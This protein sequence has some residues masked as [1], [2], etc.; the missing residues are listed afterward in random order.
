M[1]SMP[2]G[3]SGRVG[4]SLGVPVA[5]SFPPPLPT[6]MRRGI[7]IAASVP[8]PLS[9]QLARAPRSSG[10]PFRCRVPRALCVIREA[11][12][13]RAATCQDNW[14]PEADGGGQGL[15]RTGAWDQ[16]AVASRR[17]LFALGRRLLRR[18]AGRVRGVRV[19]RAGR[20]GPRPLHPVRSPG[21]TRSSGPVA[22]RRLAA[23][24]RAAP[25][26]PFPLLLCR[27]RAGTA[28]STTIRPRAVCALV[29]GW[30]G[31][32]TADHLPAISPCSGCASQ[33]FRPARRWP[34][35]RRGG[36][37]GRWRRGWGRVWR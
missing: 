12:G 9:A 4:C 19:R 37:G 16:P 34:R 2:Q 14:D 36:R 21:A 7:S 23:A 3:G 33:L 18:K 8:E 10:T 22:C 5:A 30:V 13:P 17:P 26:S 31:V 11:G 29:G 25:P 1:Q 24:K 28:A 6:D 15:G 27:K 32:L 35:A 20:L